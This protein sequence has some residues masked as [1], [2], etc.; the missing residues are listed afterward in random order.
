VIISASLYTSLKRRSILPGG[1][2]GGQRASSQY[3]NISKSDLEDD[4]EKRPASL[5][6][7]ST[8]FSSPVKDASLYSNNNNNNNNN[9][10]VYSSLRENNHSSG[11]HPQ[12]P[13]EVNSCS[14]SRGDMAATYSSFRDSPLQRDV[15]RQLK[16]QDGGGGATSANRFVRNVL[17]TFAFC[18]EKKFIL[19]FPRTNIEFEFFLFYSWLFICL[20]KVFVFALNLCSN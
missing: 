2:G 18:C 4:Q 7:T 15:R 20:Y 9:N 13:R 8:P 5:L 16:F 10:S 12:S 19:I 6:H 14:F 17:E 3:L 1:D 11:S